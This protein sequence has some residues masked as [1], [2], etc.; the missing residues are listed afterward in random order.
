MDIKIGQL[1]NDLLRGLDSRQKEVLEKRYGLKDGKN[2]TLEA[3]GDIYGVTR[4]RMR[5]IQN[6]ALEKLKASDKNGLL[7]KFTKKVS[8]HLKNVGGLRRETLLLADLQ[9]LFA[10]SS[11]SVLDNKAKFLM[12]VAGFDYSPEDKSFYSYWFLNNENKKK[13]T[14][15]VAKLAKFLE[16]KKQTVVT[17]GTID[18]IFKEAIKPH[19]LKELVALNY[20]SASKKFHVNQFGDFG[21]SN[22]SEVNPKTVRDWAHLILRKENKPLHFTEIAKMIGNVRDVSKVMNP[23]TVHNELIKDIRF[24]LVGRGIY[25]LKECGFEPGTTKEVMVR[26]LKQK[27][28]MSPDELLKMVLKERILKKNTILVNLQ[29]KKHFKRLEDGR[30]SVNM[31]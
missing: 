11:S 27:G 19:N 1:V 7:A 16:S 31:A 8:D 20:I 14:D 23:Q 18:K 15:F 2:M 26:L 4:E 21:L 3:L 10:E 13:A 30:Y 5:Q 24:V 6:S 29:N 17:A 22:W 9:L 28:P 12:E 25:G